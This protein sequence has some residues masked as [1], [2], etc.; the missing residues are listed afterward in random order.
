[1]SL[2]RVFRLLRFISRSDVVRGR[3]ECVCACVFGS[4]TRAF[5]CVQVV[6]A[7]RRAEGNFCLRSGQRV[8]QAGM[9]FSRA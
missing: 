9:L 7:V 6:H 1:M 3:Q 5:V 4:Q 8:H 2:F